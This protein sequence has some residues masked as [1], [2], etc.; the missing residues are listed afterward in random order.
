MRR[1]RWYLLGGFALILACWIGAV[2]TRGHAAPPASEGP[3][4]RIEE[5]SAGAIMTVYYPSQN[6]IYVYQSPFLNGP[7]VQCTYVFTLGAP[8]EPVTREV[9]GGH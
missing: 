7:A 9:C 2:S 3:Q 1:Q 6:K 5:A 8:G 4:I